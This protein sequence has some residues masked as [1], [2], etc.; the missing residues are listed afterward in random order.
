MKKLIVS[1]KRY[2]TIHVISQKVW[3]T[4]SSSN[5]QKLFLFAK[6]AITSSESWDFKFY[7]PVI[8]VSSRGNYLPSSRIPIYSISHFT[9]FIISHLLCPMLFL[10]PRTGFF[11]PIFSSFLSVRYFS[12]ISLVFLQV[13]NVC[14]MH[15]NNAPVA[16]KYDGWEIIEIGEERGAE[17]ERVERRK[18]KIAIESF[19]F[20][21]GGT[22]RVELI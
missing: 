8:S 1:L 6:Y 22:L 12:S 10:R 11:V 4:F 18:L 14:A 21:S 15:S 16:H 2:E 13:R 7:Y 9:F 19:P 20:L 17:R 5:F 3:L